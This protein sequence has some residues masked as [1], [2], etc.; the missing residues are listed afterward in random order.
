MRWYAG[1]TALCKRD[2]QRLDWVD[3][4]WDTQTHAL[5]DGA[6][7]ERKPAPTPLRGRGLL[8][9]LACVLVVPGCAPPRLTLGPFRRGHHLSIARILRAAK[10]CLAC[11]LNRSDEWCRRYADGKR[12]DD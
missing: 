1:L 8:A 4:D 10:I 5:F 6:R 2:S 7:R 9:A 3:G 11:V 12:K